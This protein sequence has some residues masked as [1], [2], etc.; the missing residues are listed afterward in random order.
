MRACKVSSSLFMYIYIYIYIQILFLTP[1][2][3][4][5]IA[6]SVYKLMYASDKC[7]LRTC[8][9]V[10]VY[11]YIPVSSHISLSCSKDIFCAIYLTY[12]LF[13]MY[14]SLISKS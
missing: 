1:L 3:T 11:I 5:S 13:N 10:R 8:K 4:G 2:R 7:D 9:D 6:S 12:G 14:I